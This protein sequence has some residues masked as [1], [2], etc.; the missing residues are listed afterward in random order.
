MRPD[1][2]FADRMQKKPW[3]CTL[4]TLFAS[5]GSMSQHT[6]PCHVVR[7]TCTRICVASIQTK[8]REWLSRSCQCSSRQ[9]SSPPG[10]HCWQVIC[11]G[12]WTHIDLIELAVTFFLVDEAPARPQ[13]GFRCAVPTSAASAGSTAQQPPNFQF[14]CLGN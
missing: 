1:A 6:V 5:Y 7:C 9:V 10:F 14:C 8:Q 4:L 2:C 11:R 3:P 12:L 13:F